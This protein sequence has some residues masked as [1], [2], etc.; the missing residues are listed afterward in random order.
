MFLIPE[1][2]LVFTS[3]TNLVT[4]VKIYLHILNEIHSDVLGYR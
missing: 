4:E 1:K 2:M 3:S